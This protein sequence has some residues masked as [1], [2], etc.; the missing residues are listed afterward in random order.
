MSVAR[1]NF[2]ERIASIRG[3]IS[4]FNLRDLPPIPANTL[5]N[6][7]ARIIRNGLAVQCFNIFEDFVKA[8]MEELLTAISAS[9]VSFTHL[10]FK[11]QQ[12]ATVEAIKAIEF[13]LK[14]RDKADRIQYAQDHSR[15][16]HSTMLPAI[17]LSEA[18]F[19]HAAPNISKEQFS[20]AMTALSI[21]K[22]WEQISGLCSKLGISGIPAET[23]F[24]SLAQRR[25]R[26]AHNANASIS[27][28]DLNQSLM[29]AA[30]LGLCFD[31]LLS[32]VSTL[33]CA[34]TSSIPTNK[35]LL[36][37]NFPIHIRVVK[38]DGIRFY[39]RQLGSKTNFRTNFDAAALIPDASV[40]SLRKNGVLVV[41][42]ANGNPINWII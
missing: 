13:Q 18:S 7:S 40:R 41:F 28:T 27:E 33:L 39:E 4:N 3:A 6:A 37:N 15:K 32:K 34:L 29:D 5:H 24:E 9:G 11:F 16:I 42:D 23:V 25:H 31:I 30:G 20:S 22:P 21:E 36:T 14:L 2:S 8:R 1:T 12:A 26:A 19:F 35:Q 17:Q 38:W 10:P